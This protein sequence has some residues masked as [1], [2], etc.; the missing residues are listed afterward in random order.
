MRATVYTSRSE[1]VHDLERRCKGLRRFLDDGE[2][3]AWSER[4]VATMLQRRE[5]EI[6]TPLPLGGCNA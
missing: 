1:A 2:M 4:T 5:V 3:R 6:K